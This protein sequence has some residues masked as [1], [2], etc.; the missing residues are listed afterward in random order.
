MFSVRLTT[1]IVPSHMHGSPFLHVDLAKAVC[2]EGMDGKPPEIYV[3]K[4][5]DRL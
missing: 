5:D 3:R 2:W 1:G 4:L